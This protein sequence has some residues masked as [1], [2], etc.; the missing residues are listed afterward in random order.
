MSHYVCRFANCNDCVILLTIDNLCMNCMAERDT[1][2]IDFNISQLATE[3][4]HNLNLGSSNL[5][6]LCVCGGWGVICLSVARET[7]DLMCCVVNQHPVTSSEIMYFCW[8]LWL[9]WPFCFIKAQIGDEGLCLS[10]ARHVRNVVTS[11]I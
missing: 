4:G 3:I 5:F 7:F 10:R 8:L 9:I 1:L 2:L 11:S 6:Y